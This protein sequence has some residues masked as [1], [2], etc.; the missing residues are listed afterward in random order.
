MNACIHLSKQ[1]QINETGE[2]LYLLL[3]S[4]VSGSDFVIHPFKAAFLASLKKMVEGC[5]G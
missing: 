5:L 4:A 2:N 1:E 3:I